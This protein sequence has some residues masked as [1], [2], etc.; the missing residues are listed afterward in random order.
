MSNLLEQ[1]T[2]IHGAAAEY[3]KLT[4]PELTD[5]ELADLYDAAADYLE[6]HGWT[7]AQ[8]FN[9]LTGAVCASGAVGAVIDARMVEGTQPHLY[10]TGP[11]YARWLRA[12][13][14]ITNEFLPQRDTARGPMSVSV[15][16]DIMAT[17]EYEVMDVFRGAAKSLRNNA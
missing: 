13:R 1:L 8:L 2:D 9:P 11:P 6:V 15:W 10:R 17:D 3:L 5:A 14:R 7:R 16:N 12:L 4:D